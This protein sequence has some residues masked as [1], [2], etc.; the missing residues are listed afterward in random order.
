MDLKAIQEW[1]S[2]EVAEF[3]ALFA[4]LRN[5]KSCDRMEVL[6][7]RFPTKTIHQLRDKYVEVFA[8]MLYGEIDDE[9]IIDDTTSDLCDW[10]KLLEGDTHDSVL[11]PS[12]ETSLFQPSKQLVLKVAGDQEKIQK[13][14]YK[15][16]RKERQTWTAEEHR[17]FLYGVQHFG[18]GE[19]QSISKYFV[20]SRTP[21]QL[22]SHAQKHFDRI[23]NNELD[24]RRQRHT[25][26]DVRLVN[27][28]MNNTS[29]SHTEPEREK[30]NASSISLPIL[31][32][33][34]DIL[35]DLTQGMPNFGQ[36]SNSPSNLAGQTTHCNHT[37]ESFFQW[38]GQG[39]S[40]PRKQWSVLLAQSRTEHWTWPRR[41]RHLGGAT[42]KRRRKNN[43]RTLP[44]VLTA[45]TPQEVL[46]FAQESDSGAKLSFE[47]VP[48][49]GRDL[50]TVIPP[51]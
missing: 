9:S 12:V 42:T 33:D 50:H 15:S 2:C 45:Q 29:H 37:I 11:G 35:H 47:M 48:I 31:T 4:E 30:P 13:P 23:R 6:E 27:H 17:Q 39:T 1:T 28:D 32:E 26:N 3:K 21:T 25:I 22:A 46:Q 40:S 14:H 44:H 10:Y 7:K 16:S 34:M 49:K 36:A 24:D 18:R 38:Q 20:P 19:W 41:K 5:E 43:R 8:D 51:F